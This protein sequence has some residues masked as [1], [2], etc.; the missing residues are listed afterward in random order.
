[1][2]YNVLV[3]KWNETRFANVI[4]DV[5]AQMPDCVGFQEVSG[6]DNAGNWMQKLQD[7]LGQYY[8]WVGEQRGD[9]GQ[10]NRGEYS[11]IFY[12]KDLY[13]L[14]ETSTKWLTDT[15]DVISKYDETEYYRIVT[16]ARLERKSDGKE[17]VHVNT[18][19]AHERDYI[20]S[21]KQAEVL[22]QLINDKFKDIPIFL[23]GDFNCTAGD[24]PYQV[25]ERSFADSRYDAP[26]AE[27]TAPTNSGGRI[28]DLIFTKGEMYLLK[29]DVIND[30]KYQEGVTSDH[31]PVILKCIL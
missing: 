1:M 27:P 25:I 13:T 30:R 7:G 3:S 5:L 28:I 6:A 24:P 2:S 10:A 14:K 23:T 18:H 15:P 19:F 11:C 16:W 22:V 17:F 26:Q 29:H 12:R 21:T 31:Y 9:G 20:A 8:A 4:S